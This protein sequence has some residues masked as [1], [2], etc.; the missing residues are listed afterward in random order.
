MTDEKQPPVTV[1]TV[2]EDVHVDLDGIDPSVDLVEFSDGSTLERITEIY[3]TDDTGLISVIS[4]N[5]K[6]PVGS[7]PSTDE[8]VEKYEAKQERKAT[9][10]SKKSDA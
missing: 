7:R 3:V 8:E 4:A 5:A 6:M 9:K 10:S 1:E 2:I